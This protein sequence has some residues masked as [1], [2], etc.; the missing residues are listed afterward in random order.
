[1][2]DDKSVS[3]YKQMLERV[4]QFASQTRTQLI[5]NIEKAKEKAVELEELSVHEAEQIGEYLRRDMQDAAVYLV[6]TGEELKDWFQFDVK[7]IEQRLFDMFLEVADQTK[8]EYLQLEKLA[9]WDTEYKTGEII[10]VGTLQCK[11]CRHDIHFHDTGHIPP[12]PKC[13]HTHFKR[14]PD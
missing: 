8:L 12:C 7:L 14:I 5:D 9:K 11:N 2:P 13:S 1:M 6:E 10:G 4:K 3:A